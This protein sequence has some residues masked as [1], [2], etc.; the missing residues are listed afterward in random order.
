MLTASCPP[1]VLPLAALVQQR[2]LRP[3]NA[4]LHGAAAPVYC[5]GIAVEMVQWDWPKLTC[6]RRY[7]LSKTVHSTTYINT[8]GLL[9]SFVH[10]V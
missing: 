2:R 3:Y 4:C 5:C 6:A 7:L 9:Q 1:W 10:V 8:I